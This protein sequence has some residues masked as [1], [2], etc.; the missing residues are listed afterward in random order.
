MCIRVLGKITCVRTCVRK[1]YLY[2]CV[3]VRKT[4]FCMC[5]R[6]CLFLLIC[7]MVSRIRLYIVE[8]NK[9]CWCANSVYS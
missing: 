2:V 3:Y 7:N 5:V 4:W 8:D 1:N 9:N 6:V